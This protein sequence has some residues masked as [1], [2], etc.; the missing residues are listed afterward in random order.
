MGGI[1]LVSLQDF[2]FNL[3]YR[4]ESFRKL[5]KGNIKVGGVVRTVSG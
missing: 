5:L 1:S 4:G 3:V 2:M